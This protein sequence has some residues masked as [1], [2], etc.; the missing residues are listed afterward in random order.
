LK[1]VDVK[2]LHFGPPPPNHATE[3]LEVSGP[4]DEAAE[5]HAHATTP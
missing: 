5:P 3:A 2:R 1:T 4:M